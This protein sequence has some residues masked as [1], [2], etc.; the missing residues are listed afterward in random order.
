MDAVGTTSAVARIRAAIADGSRYVLLDLNRVTFMSS[1]GL[2]ALLVLRKDLLAQGGEL[3]L[4]RLVPA[5]Q[6]VFDLTGFSR[7]FAIH[8]SR[9]DA[10]AAFGQGHS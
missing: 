5:V 1:S 10:Q 6:E 2:R 4:C 9:E 7:V 8:S 3:R